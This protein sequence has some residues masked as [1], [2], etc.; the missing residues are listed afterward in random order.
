MRGLISKMEEDKLR[1][2]DR[3]HSQLQ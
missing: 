1:M 2:L 3:Q